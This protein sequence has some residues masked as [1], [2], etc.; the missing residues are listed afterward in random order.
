[1][2]TVRLEDI[3]LRVICHLHL[4]RVSTVTVT[5]SRA[6]GVP[7]GELDSCAASGRYKFA[8]PMVGIRVKLSRTSVYKSLIDGVSLVCR[9]KFAALLLK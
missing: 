9:G 5:V 2:Y 1:M 6:L 4:I 3:H 8:A 7:R